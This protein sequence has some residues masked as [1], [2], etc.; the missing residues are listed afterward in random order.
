MKQF[1]GKL[2]LVSH[3]RTLLLGNLEGKFPSSPN[4][5]ISGKF[6]SMRQQQLCHS[7]ARAIDSGTRA[8]CQHWRVFPTWLPSSS[9]GVI[10]ILIR[11][12]FTSYE[13]VSCYSN[14][15]LWLIILYV[16]FSLFKLLSNSIWPR[17]IFF[18]VYSY[19]SFF[20]YYL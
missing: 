17:L 9:L 13:T 16:K 3:L 5:Q 15:L 8:E 20:F 7:G 1:C 6:C 10:I 11:I 4:G 2:P 18:Y 19:T 12:P 14:P